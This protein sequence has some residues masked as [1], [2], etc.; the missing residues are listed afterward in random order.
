MRGPALWVANL[1]AEQIHAELDR[2]WQ[3]VPELD[4]QAV[5]NDL[6]E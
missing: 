4:A 6:R 2:I 1:V 5:L 3:G